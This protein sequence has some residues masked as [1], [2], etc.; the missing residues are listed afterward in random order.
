MKK[1]HRVALKPTVEQEALFGQHAGYARF[2]YNWAVGEF[3]AGLDVGEWLDESTLR[4]RWNK[5]KGMIAPWGSGLSQ[6]GVK[7]AVID[8]GQAAERWGDYRRRLK[9][10]QRPGRR[11]GL[12]T[13]RHRGPTGTHLQAGALYPAPRRHRPF[14]LQPP[15]SQR[16]TRAGYRAVAHSPRA[17]EGVQCCQAAQPIAGLRNSRQQIRGPKRMPQLPQRTPPLAEPGTQGPP[18]RLP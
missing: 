12:G 17:G 6:N 7:Y 11:V 18:A 10:S 15:G 5:V 16:P 3:K 4:P 1:S 9:T 13:L 8:F 2:A 14:R